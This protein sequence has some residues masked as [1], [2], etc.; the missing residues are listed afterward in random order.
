MTIPED[1]ATLTA[2]VSA[3]FV[4]A[5]AI[6]LVM[7]Y[8]LQRALTSKQVWSVPVPEGQVAHEIRGN[9]IFV[10]VTIASFILVLHADVVRFGP[11]STTRAVLTFSALWL[12]FQGFYYA[13]HRAMHSRLL[14]RFHRHH[15]ESR[16]TS[17]L[18]G[19]SVG[20]VE[21]L[22]WMLG[23]VGMPLA[24][25]YVV[26]ISADGWAAYM[27]FNVI[28]NIVGHA[29]CEVVPPAPGLWMRSLFATVFTYHALHHARWVGHFGF[30]STW[31][32]RL[33]GSEWRDWPALHEQVWS[34]R[35]LASLKERGP[36]YEPLRGE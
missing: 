34:G 26:P 29:N 35:P 18:S 22:G 23:Y 21:S 32:D 2:Q 11:E 3:F 7:G 8:A 10:A 5:T 15:H 6:G 25:S 19:Q 30:A 20:F 24:F 14:V 4:G 17:P 9:L 27:A 33:F 36:G 31:A 28:G 13:L 16:V 12:G 1:L